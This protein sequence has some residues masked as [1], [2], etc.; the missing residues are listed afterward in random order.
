MKNN[1]QVTM[2]AQRP[3][4]IGNWSFQ[5]LKVSPTLYAREG[6][7]EPFEY[8]E[9]NE[10]SYAGGRFSTGVRTNDYGQRY[11]YVTAS[12]ELL[13]KS[14]SAEYR[15]NMI[16]FGNQI[17]YS[18]SS[19]DA[20]VDV[21]PWVFEDFLMIIELTMRKPGAA[22]DSKTDEAD[23][24]FE[25]QINDKIIQYS[26]SDPVH[27]APKEKASQVIIATTD[28][29]S[30]LSNVNLYFSGCDV[31]QEFPPGE[32]NKVDQ[33]GKGNP[34]AGTDYYLTQDKGYPPGVTTLTIKDG[35]SEATAVVEFNHDTSKKQVTM[36]I[37]SFTSKLCDIRHFSLE[38]NDY[39]NAICIAL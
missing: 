8:I 6:N 14:S 26:P 27:P 24:R 31:Y 22:A 10:L 18:T 34:G 30:I 36:T 4:A 2:S 39:P 12:H 1:K 17:T 21:F 37:K 16:K 5:H 38:D 25:V 20:S 28:K 33:H 32:I 15:F 3:F 7:N 35:F 29:F 19:L 11:S 13:F 23:R 9:V